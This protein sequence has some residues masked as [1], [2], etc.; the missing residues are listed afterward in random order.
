MCLHSYTTILYN[1]NVS[2]ITATLLY[3]IIVMCLYSYTTI[4][5]NSNVSIQL[6]YYII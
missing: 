3:Y 4:L 1:S 5:Y 2:I 6:H